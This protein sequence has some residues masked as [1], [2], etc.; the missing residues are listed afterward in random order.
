MAEEEQKTEEIVF[1]KIYTKCPACG[2]TER[3]AVKNAPKGVPIRGLKQEIM[4]LKD[5][6]HLF[7]PT[8]PALLIYSDACWD[9]GTVYVVEIVKQDLPMQVSNQGPGGNGHRPPGAFKL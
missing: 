4:P 7:S 1:P 9:C 6:S 2:S 8:V 3:L 5:V